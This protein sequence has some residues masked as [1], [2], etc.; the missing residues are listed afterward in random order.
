MPNKSGILITI[1]LTAALFSGCAG[2]S[3]KQ[4]NDVVI[5]PAFSH[6]P[7]RL[8]LNLPLKIV[9]NDSVID[10]PVIQRGNGLIKMQL[11]GYRKALSDTLNKAFIRNFKNITIT[12]KESNKGMELVIMQAKINGKDYINYHI[13]LVFNGKDIM[14]ARGEGK[15]V[16][17]TEMMGTTIYSWQEQLKTMTQR[18]IGEAIG[19]TAAAIYSE[20][21]MNQGLTKFWKKFRR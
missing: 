14:E 2:T 13:A 16:H 15:T 1:L 20:L 19:G 9:I 8:K 18:R 6:S 12:N 7:T 11:S 21:L 17:P 4:Y 5:S 3:A 10:S